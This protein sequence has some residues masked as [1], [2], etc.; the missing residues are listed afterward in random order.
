VLEILPTIRQWWSD[1][2]RVALATVVATRQSTPLPAG[3][4][5]AINDQGAVVGNISGG[6]VEGD[7]HRIAMDVISDGVPRMA[8]YGIT[9]DT[10]WSVGLMC[11]GELD[12]VVAPIEAS[13]AAIAAIVAAAEEQRAVA[14]VTKLPSQTTREHSG[15]AVD[16]VCRLA[17]WADGAAGSL[18]D[19]GLD[20]A[21]T[22][23]ARGMLQQGLSGIRRYGHSGQ[24]RADDVAVFMGSFVAP[25][26]MYVFGA[27]DFASALC[28][29][30]GHL[31]YR[32][33]VCDAREVFATRQRFPDADD[34][35]VDWPHR[36]LSSAPIDE[37]TVVCVL[38]H[39]PKFDVPVLEIA[40]R[41]PA[42]YVGAMGSRRTHQDRL[43]R[44]REAGLDDKELSRLRS[45]IGLDIGARTPQETAVSI[46]AEIILERWGG[47][48]RPLRTTDGA[49]H[50]DR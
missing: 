3:A 10:A 14:L 8:D 28:R 17:V 41:S 5:M 44:L 27:I 40:L 42:A 24:R 50:R 38:T 47:S 43:A 48:G 2:H 11:G 32:V 13:D 12:V 15:D 16:Q 35:V 39:D 4:A 36:F 49:I 6:C 34:V 19:A 7:V 22:A 37:R 18:G 46:A 1:G 20:Y 30:G 23:D 45:P 33:T 25:A 21:A 29:V 26:A 31:G 9:D